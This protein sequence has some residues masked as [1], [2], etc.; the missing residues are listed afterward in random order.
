MKADRR[1]ISWLQVLPLPAVVVLGLRVNRGKIFHPGTVNPL[2]A[3]DR[4]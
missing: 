2:Q 1:S 3:V 4:A